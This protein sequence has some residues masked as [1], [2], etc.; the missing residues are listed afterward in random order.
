LIAH[1]IPMHHAASMIKGACPGHRRKLALGREGFR[2]DRHKSDGEF[3]IFRIDTAAEPRSVRLRSG[4]GKA[5]LS[6][7]EPQVL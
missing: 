1:V 5:G 4:P 6:H 7:E 2:R 3:G